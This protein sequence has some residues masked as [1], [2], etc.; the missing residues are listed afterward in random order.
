MTLT[1]YLIWKWN[2]CGNKGKHGWIK[3]PA[4][5]SVQPNISK[6]NGSLYPKTQVLCGNKNSNDSAGSSKKRNVEI[7]QLLKYYRYQCL[8]NRYD[9]LL[10]F[11]RISPVSFQRVFVVKPPHC[12]SLMRVWR[13]PIPIPLSL[14]TWRMARIPLMECV[15]GMDYPKCMINVVIPSP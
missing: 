3:R 2:D 1:D 4:E 6:M 11:L 9:L 14:T 13:G 8:F 7:S 5:Q 10:L 15:L 12:K